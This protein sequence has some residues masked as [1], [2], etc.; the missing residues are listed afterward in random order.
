MYTLEAACRVQI[1]AQRR[2]AADRGAA[3]IVDGMG[4]QAA[5]HRGWRQ[6]RLAGL[7][8][9]LDRRNPGYDA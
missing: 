1:L 7:L 5:S 3:A 4:N 9:R 8:R 2:R 6:P